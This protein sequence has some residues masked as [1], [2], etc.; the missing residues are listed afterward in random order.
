[1][2]LT[3]ENLESGLDQLRG[4]AERVDRELRDAQERARKGGERLARDVRTRAET[5]LDEARET[6]RS[7]RKQVETQVEAHP[8]REKIEDLRK[9]AEQRITDG[10][11]RALAFLPVA[12][13]SELEKMNRKLDRLQRKLRNLEKTKSA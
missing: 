3:I 12:R 2:L 9:N 8:L 5:R 1:M 6:A 10:L 7:I 11:E 13:R 4:A